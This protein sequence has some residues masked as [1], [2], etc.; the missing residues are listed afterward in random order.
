MSFRTAILASVVVG[1]VAVAPFFAHA[2]TVEQ[3]RLQITQLLTQ[4]HALQS[5]LQSSSL[6]SIA[7]PPVFTPGAPTIPSPTGLATFQYSR[8]PDLQFNLEPGVSDAAVAQEVTMLQRFLAQD[9]QLYPEQVV[10]G[11]YGPAT[12]R[13]VQRFQARHGIVNSGNP[14]STGY[15]RTGPRTRWAI[16]NSCGI[17]PTNVLTV[18]PSAGN[19]PVRVSAAFTYRGSN[20]TAYVL[21]WGDDSAPLVQQAPAGIACSAD[22]V[23][24]EATHTYLSPGVYTVTLRLG[25]G[26]TP[27][28]QNA[29][30]ATVVVEG[31]T[32]P[33]QSRATLYL[34]RTQGAVPLSVT[35]T[36]RSD[37]PSSCASY[38]LDWGDGTQ[39][40]RHN[41]D[42]APCYGNDSLLRTYTHTYR[43]P[44]TYTVRARAGYG[45][46]YALNTITQQVRV[47][48][49]DATQA[50]FIE[51]TYGAAPLA[52]QMRALFG[53]SLCDGNLTY[54]VDWGDGS[55]SP[56]RVCADASTRFERFT[57][58][59]HTPGTYTAR[60]MQSHPN[61]RFQE[62]S[63]TIT[64][65]GNTHGGSTGSTID[66]SRDS[67]GVR[68]VNA[69][70]R[71][72]EFTALINAAR[73]CASHAYSIAFGD[74]NDSLQSYPVS[75]CQ[76][77][78]RTVSHTYDRNGTYT[79]LLLRNGIVVDQVRVTVSG[80]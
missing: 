44:G 79:A 14:A 16:K 33:P 71:T 43:T 40:I 5:Q 69:S 6:Q 3:L 17:A 64:V 48:T 80:I 50:C 27:A 21:D 47:Q 20:C 34:T 41:R 4:V 51:P 9:P 31:S 78:T 10:N 29:G 59:Y 12:E 58:T 70:R 42:G 24:K 1:S 74:G 65:T 25:Q 36:L 73:S 18:S 37:T 62:Q 77:A 54:Q 39:P 19:A 63:C 26:G 15:G 55:L 32:P 8:C 11:F 66:T 22:T 67:L 60:L 45:S 53:G 46:V 2:Q 61:A 7:P 30:S 52:T 35:A 23:R 28:L 13:A 68:V 56:Q 57:H 75:T 76:R 72:V 38:E 49:P